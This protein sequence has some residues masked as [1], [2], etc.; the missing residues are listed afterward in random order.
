MCQMGLEV[1]ASDL[2]YILQYF[3]LYESHDEW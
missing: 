2:S 3:A 1:F